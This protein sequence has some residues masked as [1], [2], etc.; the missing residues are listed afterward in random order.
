M[1]RY[2]MLHGVLVLVLTLGGLSG[3]AYAEGVVQGASKDAAKGA[4]KGVAQELNNSGNLVHGAKQVTKGVVDGVS[5]ALPQA[6][7]Q[8]VNQANVNKKAMGKVARTVTS[9]AVAG[10]VDATVDQV[11][12]ALG[13]DADGKLAENMAAMTEKMAAA[14]VRGVRSELPDPPRI[15]IN[16]WPMVLGVVIGAFSTLFC[17]GAML[18]LYLAF[19]R[20]RPDPAAVSNAGH[21]VHPVGS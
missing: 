1:K 5:D 8:I 13:E 6:T 3:S 18:L 19:Q 20:R 12:R 4:I 2:N 17:A 10:A 11:N 9:Q 7:S 14:L 16:P 21:S 15:Q